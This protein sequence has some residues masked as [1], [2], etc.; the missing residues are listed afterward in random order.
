MS[1]IESTQKKKQKKKQ[2]QIS[3][4]ELK[5]EDLIK[6][7]GIENISTNLKES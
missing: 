7:K 6:F 1:Q 4:F 5:E 3:S 2:A